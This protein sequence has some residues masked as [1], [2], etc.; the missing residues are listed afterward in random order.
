MSEDE[1]AKIKIMY[2]KERKLTFRECCARYV[3]AFSD[4]VAQKLDA[5]FVKIGSYRSLSALFGAGTVIDAIL[6]DTALEARYYQDGGRKLKN[7]RR[8]AEAAYT[9]TGELSVP[10]F[11]SSLKSGGF[12]LE[13][14]VGQRGR[15]HNHDDHALL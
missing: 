7:V 14:G 8:L 1:L 6:R 5:F 13:L 11:L 4:S 3:E 2:Q 9:R 10:A 15:Q 12:D